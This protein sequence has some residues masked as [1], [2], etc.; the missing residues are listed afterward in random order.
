M[1]E[2]GRGSQAGRRKLVDQ[3]GGVDDC[4]A[5]IAKKAGLGDEYKVTHRPL[6]ESGLDL[7]SLLGNEDNDIISINPLGGGLLPLDSAALKLLRSSRA[8]YG[9]LAV[10]YS[11]FSRIQAEANDMV[12]GSCE[13]LDPLI[14][15]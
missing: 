14:R 11:G 12:N 10:A 9:N 6:T 1:A 7:S 8:Q 5:Y 15:F 13:P 3:I 2:S 4:I